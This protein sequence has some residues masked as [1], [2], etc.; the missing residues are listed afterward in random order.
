MS[1]K[2]KNELLHDVENLE[3]ECRELKDQVFRLEHELEQ[4]TRGKKTEEFGVIDYGTGLLY[5]HVH[6]GSAIVLNELMQALKD[7]ALVVPLPTLIKHIK[8]T[9]GYPDY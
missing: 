3:S 7:A 6:K 2:T 8:K 4:A 9:P 1:K 5:Y